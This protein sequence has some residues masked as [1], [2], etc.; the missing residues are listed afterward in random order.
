MQLGATALGFGSV[1][2]SGANAYDD[3]VKKA[4]GIEAKDQITGFLYIGTPS[5]K[6]GRRRRPE[7]NDHVSHWNAPLA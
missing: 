4:L 2:L 6:P 3:T 1:W 7:L 5:E